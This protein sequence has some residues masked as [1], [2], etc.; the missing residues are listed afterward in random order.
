MVE[1]NLQKAQLVS[2]PFPVINHSLLEFTIGIRYEPIASFSEGWLLLG[3]QSKPKAAGI[4][5]Y[6]ESDTYGVNV[7]VSG[8]NNGL[9]TC[10]AFAIKST[11][12]VPTN[13]TIR[14]ELNCDTK[15]MKISTDTW[16]ECIQLPHT[17]P[18]YPHF[19]L[20]GASFTILP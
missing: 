7:T 5:S 10:G 6:F 11:L 8:A 18:W 20:Y 16:T 1:R 15:S 12:V 2:V 17:G 19:N 13:G 4:S 9:Y 14:V 3:V